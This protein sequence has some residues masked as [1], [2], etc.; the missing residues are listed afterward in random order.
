MITCR[1][2]TDGG[3]TAVD[4]AREVAAFLDEAERTL[5]LAVYD[6]KLSGD[7]EEVVLG[8][9]RAAQERGVAV[10]VA[11]NVSHPNPIPVPPPPEC[12]PEDIAALPAQTL[13]VSG[14]PGPHAPQVRRAGRGGRAHG[15][16][17]LD[18]RL[19]DAT[20]ERHDLGRVG[21]ARRGVLAG[22]RRALVGSSGD[23]G[24]ACR[25][26]PRRR[27]Q[28]RRAAVV[29]PGLRGRA[30]TP[31]GEGDRAGEAPR[32]H[33]LAGHLRRARAGDAR[34]GR[35]RGSRG[36]RP[37]AWT[38]RSSRTCTSSGRR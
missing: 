32:A 33:L 27:R 29:L 5:E 8:A 19:L 26:A 34:A 2:L 14:H 24:G 17:E 23:R 35:G 37:A 12:V 31:R 7:A 21:R 30:L 18:G 16:D 13:A 38:R 9:L 36:R 3:Q 15:F 20:G 25:A 22:V 11:F 10:R 1:T 28:H 4:V 6:I